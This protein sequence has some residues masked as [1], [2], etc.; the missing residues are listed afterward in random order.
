MLPALMTLGTLDTILRIA[1]YFAVLIFAVK[2]SQA[3]NIYINKH[4]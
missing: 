1:T 3:F 2:G 4:R